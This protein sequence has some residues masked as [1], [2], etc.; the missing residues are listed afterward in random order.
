MIVELKKNLSQKQQELFDSESLG[1]F[2]R[3]NHNNLEE[4]LKNLK[5]FAAW[6]NEIDR[7][8]LTSP[9]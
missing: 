2:L 7:D 3:A 5:D 8:V 4:T 6:H 9:T 1:K